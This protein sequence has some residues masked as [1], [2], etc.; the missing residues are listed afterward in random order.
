M[1]TLY[2]GDNLEVLKKHVA[3]E[4]VD[5]IYLDPP[6][7]SNAQYSLIYK[8]PS[9]SQVDAQV[10][11][12]K[13]MWRWEE[14]A[15]PLAM[16]EIRQR[17]VQLFRIMHALQASLGEG[18]MMAY[19]AM[20]A[21]RMLELHRVLKPTGSLYLHCDSTAS[22]YLKVVLD[23]IFGREH[24]L[25]ELI[26]KR[27]SAHTAKRF[28]PVHDT[29]LFYA[30][31]KKYTW[32]QVRQPIPQ[33]TIDAWYNNIEE[34]TG[35]R[36]NRADLTA[37]GV[38]TGSSG[39]AWRGRNVTAKGRHWA[40]PGFVKLSATDTLGAL[41]ELDKLGRLHWPKS[42]DGMPMLKRYLDES[43]GVPALDVISD[44]PPLN[45][46]AKERLGYPTQKPLALMERLIRASSN[47]GDVVLDPF[48]GCGTTIHAAE[49]LE[50]QWIGID[51]AYAAIQVIEDRLSTW[52][53]QS[54][55]R[56][57]GIPTAEAEARALA[58]LDPHTFQ[59]WAV[60]R[61]GGQPRGKGADRGI[62]G[63]IIFLKG[64][65]Q[66]GR[67]IVS[68]KA[69]QNVNPGMVRDLN[70]VVLR[71]GA[72]LGA[73]VCLRASKEM[74]LEASRSE[75]I[76]LPGGP[77]HRIQ[78]V[79]VADLIAGPNLGILTEL[80]VIQA[81]QAAKAEKKP[82]RPTPEKLRAERPLPPM[83][84]TGGRKQPSLPLDEPV[85]TQQPE[86]STPR[87]RAK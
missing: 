73:F 14:D 30:K 21:V 83:A 1:N 51:V 74:K 76:Q 10:R 12:F 17:D 2:F 84:I 36:F 86:R 62:D 20:M 69:G 66:Y 59:Q 63:E 23:A 18:D 26:W 25:N 42:P 85:L 67:G 47:P 48:C 32:N 24:F 82:R 31:S 54:S 6:F 65:R 16:D 64:V 87:R 57:D 55:Y 28:A 22:H 5:L 19:L 13:D 61:L 44:I 27:S 58:A 56:V 15:A 4:S 41:E 43:P 46:V 70:G 45:N 60:G 38:R 77:R 80:N 34:G 79:E 37:S 53:P 33:E 11:A 3:A 29:V 78:I 50:R 35:R 7:N 81:A 71:E 68:V 8:T 72:D 40:I 75:L 39:A 49:I 52:L 9:G